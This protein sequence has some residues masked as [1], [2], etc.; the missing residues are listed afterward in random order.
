MDFHHVCA[1]SIHNFLNN[2][3][4]STYQSHFTDDLFNA[5]VC[6]EYFSFWMRQTIELTYLHLS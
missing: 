4:Y 3:L 5:S 1:K 2:S 6:Y